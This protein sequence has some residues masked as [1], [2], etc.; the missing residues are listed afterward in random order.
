[1][2]SKKKNNQ[3]VML[4]VLVTPEYFTYLQERCLA[5]DRKLSQLAR[6]IL[7][8]ERNLNHAKE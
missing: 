5:E 3:L 7:Y 6:H 4:R 2:K 1:M 8:Q